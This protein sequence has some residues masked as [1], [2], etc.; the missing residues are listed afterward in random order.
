LR[1]DPLQAGSHLVER[2]GNRRRGGV[3]HAL[4]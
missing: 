4:I 1:A 3:I 2:G